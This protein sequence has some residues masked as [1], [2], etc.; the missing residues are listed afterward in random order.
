MTN[1]TPAIFFGHGNPLNALAR[2]AWTQ[3]WAT[4]GASI[5]RPRAI[6][7]VSAHWYLPATLVTAQER[8]R[9]IHDFGGFPRELYEVKYPAPGS[10][11]LARRV[12]ELLAPVAVGLDAS[13]G[14]DHGTWSVLRHVFPAADMPIVQLSIDETQPASFHY[15][16]GKRLAPLRDEDI[17]IVGSGNLV[18]NLHA[19]AWGRH[20][21]EPLDWAVRFDTR[22]RE[23]IAANDHTPLINYE[24]LG[25]DATLSAP[26]PDHYLPLLY[27]IATRREGDEITFPV[28]GFDGGSISMLTVRVG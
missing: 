16:L 26:T 8:P 22:A 17:L 4:I 27:V 21:V 24:S 12:Q 14:L 18:H 23:L 28:E 9:T 15:E 25:R 5:P 13:W 1:P 7:C 11:T 6:L 10:P 20:T 2:N 3:G 19:Y